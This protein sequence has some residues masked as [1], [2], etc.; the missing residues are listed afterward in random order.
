MN[1]IPVF[2]SAPKAF[3]NR[4]EE[5]L[6]TVEL[7]L[8]KHDLCPSTLGRSEYSL[9]APLE[10]IRRLMVGSCGLLCLGFR[11]TQIEKGVDRPNS[12]R[13]EQSRSIDNAWLT[14]AYCQIEPAM[15][16]QIGIPVLVWREAGVVDDGVFDRGAAGLSMPQFNLD[17][18][19]D[20][21][22]DQWG[23]P[24]REWIDQVRQ[25][26]YNRGSPPRQW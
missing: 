6:E 5:F 9:S 19:P 20:L 17:N 10:A 8:R 2:V 21:S 23:Q 18:P 7:A 13:D 3:L 26:Y 25:V 4:Q 15:A 1:K 14:S 24:L 12:D 11:K 22:T 16:Y